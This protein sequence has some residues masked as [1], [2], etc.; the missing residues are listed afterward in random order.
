MLKVVFF[1]AAGTLFDTRQ[2]VG[3]T[4]A[5]VARKYGVDAR[6]EDVNAAFRRVFHHTPGLAFG[7]GHSAEELR[8]LE[9]GWWYRLV[10]ESF[11]RLGTFAGFDAYFAE[12]FARFG[13]TATWQIDPRALPILLPALALDR[14]HGGWR[15]PLTYWWAARRGRY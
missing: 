7:P 8:N 6:V 11:E 14:P 3:A 1:D 4:Y 15:T 10:R 13:S 9:R 12:L 5:E 2:P